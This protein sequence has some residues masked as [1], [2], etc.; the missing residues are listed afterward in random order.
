MTCIYR[1]ELPLCMHSHRGEHKSRGIGRFADVEACLG[2]DFGFRRACGG[3]VFR[4]RAGQACDSKGNAMK[5][6]KSIL[7]SS[8][9]TPDKE[10]A[11]YEQYLRTKTKPSKRGGWA[12]DNVLLWICHL[13]VPYFRS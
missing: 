3:H 12:S 8:G 4:F 9:I 6:R 5:N 10:P 2:S 13:P 1:Q 11:L 7:I